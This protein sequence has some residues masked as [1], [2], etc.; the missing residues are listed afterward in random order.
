MVGYLVASFWGLGS[1]CRRVDMPRCGAGRGCRGP[2][3][4]RLSPSK[5]VLIDHMTIAWPG[6]K[7][8][9]RS[10][11]AIDP[12]FRIYGSGFRREVQRAL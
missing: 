7:Q 4:W 9:E 11:E 6:Y 1:L 8:L 12:G 2:F 10:H 3:S 5:G